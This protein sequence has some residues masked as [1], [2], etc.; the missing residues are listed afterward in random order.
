LIRDSAL[1]SRVVTVFVRTIFSWQR[2]LAK[3]AGLSAVHTGSV[4]MVQ[5]FDSLLKLNPHA[6][7]W[8]ADGVF[9]EMPDHSLR[10]HRLDPP[11]DADVASLC[12][13]LRTRILKLIDTDVEECID[14]DDVAM[15]AT[16]AHAVQPAL[17]VFFD[18]DPDEESPCPRA[19]LSALNEGFSL[20]AGLAASAHNRSMLD[21]LLRYGTR[22]PF[23]KRRLSLLPDGNVRLQLHK[24]YDTGQ[25]A[26]VLS[27]LAFLKRLAAII[28][29]PNWHLVRY[30]G[31]FSS[32]HHGRPHLKALL[33]KSKI[34]P[35]QTAVDTHAIDDIDTEPL[36]P[37][38]R[39]PYAVLL[40]RVF[41]SDLGACERCGGKMRLIA[42]IDDPTV[43]TKILS[44]LG[45]DTN[46]PKKT[47]ARASPQPDF[48]F[49]D[50]DTSSDF[51]VPFQLN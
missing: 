33:P 14:D 29:P 43:I 8:I 48:D 36:P 41:A 38:V 15:A 42:H 49:V 3:Q 5:R 39:Y 40:A 16:Q 2:K 28:P 23:A 32:P 6:H 34:P 9:V 1:F 18:T 11:T 20:H 12:D 51:E 37:S 25:T 21:R 7:S 4:T 35:T 46:A 31:I 44:H 47:P 22:P 10:F 17:P 30:H 50:G 13:R 26:I 45:L 19:P 24:P 27:P